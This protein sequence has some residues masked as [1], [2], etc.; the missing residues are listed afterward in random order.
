MFKKKKIESIVKCFIVLVA[1]FCML[2]FQSKDTTQAQFVQ[3]MDPYVAD[4]FSVGPNGFKFYKVSDDTAEVKD[5]RGDVLMRFIHLAVKGSDGKDSLFV[6]NIVEIEKLSVFDS[7]NVDSLYAPS[8][9]LRLISSDFLLTAGDITLTAGALTLTNGA[10]TLTNAGL[11]VDTVITDTIN[12]TTELNIGNG[13]SV[14]FSFADTGF[15]ADTVLAAT[16]KDQQ[17]YC[18]HHIESITKL[19]KI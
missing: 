4:T 8:G 10:L 14:Q 6:S 2:F 1:V 3:R 15:S 19:R 9:T 13:T 16:Y 12:Y 17:Y 7:L 5:T 18:P 11:S